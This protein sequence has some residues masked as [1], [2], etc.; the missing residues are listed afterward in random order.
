MTYNPDLMP[1]NLEE[2]RQLIDHY[3]NLAITKYDQELQAARDAA[4]KAWEAMPDSPDK[5]ALEAAL[6]E[7]E[8]MV[9]RP[10]TRQELEAQFACFYPQEPEAIAEPALTPEQELA[11]KIAEADAQTSAA[12]L[13]GFDYDT[14]ENQLHFSYDA[15]DQQNFADT[16]NA[17]LLSKSGVDGLPATVTWNA[18]QL[19]DGDLV[20]LELTADEFLELYTKGALAHKAA[21]MEAGG[22]RKKEIYREALLA[23]DGTRS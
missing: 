6:A 1:A 20:Q 21:C 19:S 13:A 9:A 15:F 2:W 18:Y 3:E 5:P 8:S 23:E 11:R 16:A 17:C 7:A 22:Q 4:R 14:G 10:Q 12:I